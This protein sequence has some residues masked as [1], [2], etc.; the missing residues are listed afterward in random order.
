M[1]APRKIP[2][3]FWQLL[4]ITLL[5]LPL[6]MPL[7]RWTS[8]P[9]TH[10]GHLH[11]HR[12]A[13]MRH[14]WESGVYFTRWLP[15]LAFGYGYPFF[16]YREPAPLYAALFPH[17]LGLPL[18]AAENLF[19]SLCILASGWFMFLWVR[20][21]FGSRA[22]MVS[23]VAYMSA[24]YVLVDAL[25][26]G[27][28]PESLALPLLPLLLWAGRRWLLSGR[29]RWFVTAVFSLALFSLS[30]NIS[31]LI[32]VPT[33]LVYLLALAYIEI[34]I[35]RLEIRRLSISPSPGVPTA[36]LPISNL[37][38]AN[39]AGL[40]PLAWK[41]AVS[42]ILLLFILGLGMTLFYA[43]GALLEIDAVTLQ[44]STTTRNNDFHYNFA[45][46]R[47]IFAPVT[48]EDPTLLNPPLLF[49]LGWVTTGLAILGVVRWFWLRR[50]IKI[51]GY[52]DIEQYPNIPISQYQLRE[53]SG[54]IVLMVLATAVFLFMSLAASLFIWENVPLIDFV[55]F[56]WR[57]VGRAALPMAM[58]A[59]VPF[60]CASGQ[61]ASG[62]VASGQ[63]ASGQVAS[64]QVASGKWQAASGKW[65]VASGQVASD[66]ALRT[67]HYA[68]R[69][70]FF[71]SIPLLILEAI[72]NLYPNYCQEQPFPT[73]LTVHGYEQETKMVG[74]DPEGSYFPRSV[75]ERPEAS[76]LEADYQSG[77]PPQRLDRTNLPEGAVVAT[78]VYHPLAATI[79]LSSPQPFTATYLS[80]AFPGWQ[81]T[82]AGEP[83][84]ITPSDP[85]G[86]IT[87]PIPAGTHT[88]EVFWSSTPLRTGL[89]AVSLLALFAVIAISVFGNRL[90]VISDRPLPEPPDCLPI[91]DYRLLIT[92][93]LLMIT[94][95]LVVDR[96]DNPLRRPAVPLVRETAVL[97]G[98]ELRL[99]GYNLSAAEVKSGGTFDVDMAWTAVD[100]PRA[101]YQS[102]LW[103]AGPDG[104]LWSEKETFRPRLYEDA[105]PTVFWQ[106]GQ[107]AWDSREVQVL[108]GT[109][110]GTYDLVLTLFDRETLQPVTLLDEAGNVVGPTAV[111]GQIEVA[112]PDKTPTF[113]P[114]N[115]VNQPI[116]SVGWTL[117]GYSQDR[118]EV[119]P[120]DPFLLT[121]FWERNEDPSDSF[122]L[123]LQDESGQMVREWDL[124]FT[125]T[126]RSRFGFAVSA[127][128]LPN[129]T[130]IRS[131]HLLRLP[132][133]LVDG[134]YHF[135]IEQTVPLGEVAINAPDRVFESVEMD[136]AVEIPFTGP[137]AAATLTG[138]TLS[139][140]TCHLP[141]AS[142]PLQ[143]LWRA[144]TTFPT[145]YHVFVH[146]V[147][148]NGQLIAQSDGEPANWTRPTTGWLPGEYILD[149]HTL[150]L[151]ETL[152]AGQLALRVGLYHPETGERLGMGT[153]DY[154]EIPIP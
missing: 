93:A 69:L 54:H 148:E 64:G 44:Q 39:I 125:A 88:V 92:L 110:P 53:Q 18:P 31:L 124:P 34:E 87:F 40:R 137:D 121:L 84:P 113:T 101:R 52:W 109:P 57:F 51:L 68:L 142:C 73:I 1:S 86:L 23:A 6:I 119:A 140:S 123:T 144:D 60:A 14:A 28:A 90:A 105:P 72:P 45:S 46:L 96:T 85:A 19:Y 120:G 152:P 67:T 75:Q 10:D 63:V 107:W 71:L 83:V 134:R 4:I 37:Q 143:L 21:V 132:V 146:L 62:Q 26:R 58:L 99:N 82:I 118:E 138:Y 127:L 104:L 56:P 116:G 97:Q 49:R 3:T 35:G 154:V 89:T 98:R 78:A 91:T 48:P 7:L 150:T 77:Q 59:G 55:Q 11:Y 33:L 9:C 41:T 38:A 32:F 8:V 22:G 65:Q 139:A 102:N 122:R 5:G 147:D 43:G 79:Q 149:E 111:L 100:T 94:L 66:Y 80:F 95:K 129:H 13:A 15:D 47:E 36:D 136:T 112:L 145:S 25:V 130:Q 24:P 151:P 50:D 153:A 2:A 114:P 70:L 12:V 20:D 61:V 27:N 131:Q 108:P 128:T 17:L 106:P 81:A 29:A 74:V 126:A 103:L 133:D 117:L 76:P 135:T 30:H 16:V 141:L 115:V 42:R